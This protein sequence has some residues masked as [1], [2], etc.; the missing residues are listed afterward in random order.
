MMATTKNK[1]EKGQIISF[2]HGVAKLKG[3]THVSLHEI[4]VDSQEKPMALVVGFD[5][6]F[7]EALFFK[8][9]VN[10]QEPVFRSHEG[11]QVFVDDSIIGRIVNGLGQPRDSFGAMAGEKQM[12]FQGAPQIIEREPVHVPLSTGIK[13]IDTT[14][15]IG[16]GQRELI[17][18]D[19]NLGKSTLAIDAVLNQ[20]KAQPPVY[21]IYV[22]CGQKKEKLNDL[23]NLFERYNAFLY[24]IIVAAPAGSSFAELYLAP[25]VGTAIG[26]YFRDQGKDALV[27]YDDLTQH[28]KAYRDIALLLERSPGREAYPG[29]IFSLHAGL[30]ERSAKLSK[31]KGGGSL[32]ALPIIETQENDITSFIPTNLISITD[33]QIYFERGLFEKGFL[34]AVNIGLSV[35]RVGSQAQPVPLKEVTGGLRLTLAQHRELQKL[36]KLETTKSQGALNKI[37][38]GKLLLE[39]LK[40]NKHTGI[41]WEE[42]TVLLY[43]LEKGVFDDLDSRD[44]VRLENLFLQMLR[45]KYW[46]FLQDLRSSHFSKTLQAKVE[47]IVQDFK[48]EFL[49]TS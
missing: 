44:W 37:R 40:Q 25:F 16:R 1:K 46:D 21:C 47:E 11:L 2:F 10:V 31:A 8:P 30:L 49:S 23:V 36:A 27:V 42:Q 20:Q 38:R 9:R 45:T 17:I 35:S 7:I 34:P 15:P 19:R 5:K 24:S 4:L 22:L 13:I 32:T 3:L 28:A 14:L 48:Q 41:T 26:E 33:G 29:N 18:G 43:L 6:D 12:V 39:F